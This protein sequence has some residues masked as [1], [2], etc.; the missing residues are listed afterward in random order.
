[1]DKWAISAKRMAILD[2]KWVFTETTFLHE[3]MTFQKML[4]LQTNCF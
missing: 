3:K 2:E 4:K 1:M